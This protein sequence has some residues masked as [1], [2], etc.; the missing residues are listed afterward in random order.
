MDEATRAVVLDVVAQLLKL[1]QIELPIPALLLSSLVSLDCRIDFA[2]KFLPELEARLAAGAAD[3]AALTAW[4]DERLKSYGTDPRFLVKAGIGE[5]L[6]SAA[7][8]AQQ[9]KLAREIFALS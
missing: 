4:A 6:Q 5:Y 2:R 7:L 3:A 9:A 8:P 1:V